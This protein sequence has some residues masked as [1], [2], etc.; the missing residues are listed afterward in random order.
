MEKGAKKRLKVLLLG[1]TGRIGPGLIDEYFKKNIQEYELIIGI[2]KRGKD[3]GLKHRKFRLRSIASLR[4]AMKGVDVVVHLAANSNE[5]AG[6]NEILEP[7]IVGAY[8]VFEAARLEKVKR[9]IFASSVHAIRGYPLG[10]KVKAS[11]AAKPSGFYGASKV[12]G[13]NLC[14][15]YSENCD[16]SCLA[17][18]VGAYVSDDLKQR[19]CVRRENFDYVIT[20]RDMLQ[21]IHKCI[22]AP[23]SVKYG[24]FAGISNN[25]RKYM[26]LKHARKILGYK[27]E[28]D[29]YKICN[30]IKK[31]FTD[32]IK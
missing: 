22:L 3:F 32:E 9:I 14:Y 29:A 12:F 7:N 28:D 20:Q 6:F 17:I 4:K 31:K 23:E 5:M 11:W 19:V 27:P 16:M 21:L 8:N 30:Q 2:H 15:I 26:D 24:I 18:R 10:R 13:E 1:A 25:K